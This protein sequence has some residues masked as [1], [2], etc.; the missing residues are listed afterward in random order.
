MIIFKGIEEGYFAFMYQI[1][2]AI[3]RHM[4]QRKISPRDVTML[5]DN[6]IASI[7]IDDVKLS[8]SSQVCN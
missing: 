1:S 4:L 3:K 8:I 6:H 5:A 2:V 7:S